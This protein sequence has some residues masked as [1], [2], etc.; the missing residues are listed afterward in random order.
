MYNRALYTETKVVV[1]K[2]IYT[3]VLTYGCESWALTTKIE[4]ILQSK[5]MRHL[6][7]VVGKTRRG[8]IR[9]RTI[10]MG[11]NTEPLVAR[12]K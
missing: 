2:T 7:N 9:N 4:S 3:P 8:K 5:E 1:Y 10:R 12:I 6:R 11:L